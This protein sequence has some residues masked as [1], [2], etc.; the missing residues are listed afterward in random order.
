[1]RVIGT[2]RKTGKKAIATQRSKPVIKVRQKIRIPN[3]ISR[4]VG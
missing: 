2:N 4:K 1:M 3:T